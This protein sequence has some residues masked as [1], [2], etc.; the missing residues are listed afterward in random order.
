LHPFGASAKR[1]PWYPLFAFSVSSC[2]ALPCRIR[3]TERAFANG[4]HVRALDRLRGPTIVMPQ[5]PAPGRFFA[6]WFQ[7]SDFDQRRLSDA[8]NRYGSVQFRV[9]AFLTDAQGDKVTARR[10]LSVLPYRS[11]VGCANADAETTSG[12]VKPLDCIFHDAN[13]TGYFGFTMSLVEGLSWSNWG[14]PVA[15]ASG[16]YVGNMGYRASAT[17]RLSGLRACPSHAEKV[18]TQFA[19]TTYGQFGFTATRRLAGCV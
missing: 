15:T 19:V 18:Y 12:H 6:V 5:Q 14:S 17:V 8:V 9:T 16:T 2:S 3:L 11:V 4:R 1:P 13:D 7:R 10:T